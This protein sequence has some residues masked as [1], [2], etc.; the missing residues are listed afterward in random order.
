MT[1][2]NDVLSDFPNDEPEAQSLTEL[3]HLVKSLIPAGQKVV[4]IPP[5]ATVAE[6][7]RIMDR[8]DFSQL[9][10]AAGNIVLG[11][12]SY[13]SLARHLLALGPVRE[14]YEDLPVDEFMEDLRFVQSTDNWASILDYLDSDDAV[15]VG[16]RDR[17]QG[18][19]TAMDVLH[20]LHKIA[21]P[22][23]LLAEIELTLRR[24]IRAC[25]TR[26]ELQACI[27][28]S[29]ASRYDPAEMP[30]ELNEMTFNDHVQMIRDGR[31]WPYFE[32]VFGKGDRQ[33]KATASRLEE[34]RDL[35]NE[36]FHF[37]RQLT[38]EDHDG[39]AGHRKWLQMKAMA[40]EARKRAESAK[41]TVTAP[42]EPTA[43]TKWNESTFM[44]AI[45]KQSGATSMSVAQAILDWAREKR[46]WVW[47][48]RGE[49]SGSFV[50]IIE[51]GGIQHQLLAVYT[52]GRLEVYFQYYQRKP[53]FESEEKR[54]E[55][56]GKLNAIDGIDIPVDGITR[57]PSIPL[58][59]L[60]EEE[61]R[62]RFLNVLDWIV[63]EIKKA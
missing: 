60:A 19:V 61:I 1:N 32:V 4:S 25:V 14:G 51:R 36:L 39:L 45:Q 27:E 57:R 3:F 13:R 24:I 11:V 59:V 22:F 43:P 17:L 35:R 37:R 29:L 30:T 9:P 12:V 54:L 62:R 55:L 10:V 7:L 63:G 49:K 34:T 58:D 47:W 53:P 50:P 5:D 18:I 26:D 15:L 46:T 48:G 56:L 42:S 41:R 21:N 38:T 23:V 31:N 2:E 33:R 28:N 44:A 40:Y 6:A 52:Y 8:E 20:Y 16:Q